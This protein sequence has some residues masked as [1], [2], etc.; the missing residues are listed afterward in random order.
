MV[1]HEDDDRMQEACPSMLEAINSYFFGNVALQD[2]MGP[3]GMLDRDHAYAVVAES[4]D[5]GLDTAGLRD[6]GMCRGVRQEIAK[7]DTP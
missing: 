3:P 5:K 7:R 4:S 2:Q 1:A 6:A